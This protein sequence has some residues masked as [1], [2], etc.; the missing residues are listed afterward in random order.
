MKW[1]IAWHTF[2]NY[3]KSSLFFIV[4][5]FQATSENST[6]LRF[7]CE[8]RL[9]QYAC[10]IYPGAFELVTCGDRNLLNTFI[11]MN[12]LQLWIIQSNPHISVHACVSHFSL[13]KLIT[14]FCVLMHPD[15]LEYQSWGLSIVS[16]KQYSQNTEGRP[17][18]SWDLKPAY[19]TDCFFK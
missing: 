16:N 10:L 13:A 6:Y 1:W 19:S 3:W 5:Y 2:W 18:R 7:G 4:L 9:W 15:P 17:S 8:P 12:H 14:Y 11:K